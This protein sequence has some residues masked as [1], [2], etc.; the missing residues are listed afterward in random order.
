MWVGV[1]RGTARGRVRRGFGS[2]SC[3]FESFVKWW[4]QPVVV[5]LVGCICMPW[6]GG[7]HSFCAGLLHDDLALFGPALQ[8]TP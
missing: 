3:E 5:P 8:A 1:V 7:I 2:A 6:N 4:P